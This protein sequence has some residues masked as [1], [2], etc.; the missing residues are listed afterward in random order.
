[1]FLLGE[2]KNVSTFSPGNCCN[3][4]AMGV[5]V[6][7][8]TFTKYTVVKIS[9]L[10]FMSIKLSTLAPFVVPGQPT[11]FQVGEVSDTGVELTWEPAFEKEGIISYELHYKEGSQGTQVPSQQQ[12]VS[13]IMSGLL[14]HI[15]F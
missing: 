12:T 4:V 9:L 7:P 2:T 5:N 15:Q 10:N 8:N 3:P 1:M 11:N 14:S 13:N 6:F